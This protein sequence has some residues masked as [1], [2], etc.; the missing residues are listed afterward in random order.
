MS[1]ISSLC[2]ALEYIAREMDNGDEWILIRGEDKKNWAQ[3][4][5]SA[6]DI[7]KTQSEKLHA[8]AM[9]RND[10]Y[11]NGG[12]ISCDDKLPE[13]GKYVLVSFEFRGVCTA[14][15]AYAHNGTSERRWYLVGEDSRYSYF[16]TE[17]KAWRPLP[18]PY[19][20]EDTE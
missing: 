13:F 11:Y 15:I 10:Q 20:K 19:D 16:L 7:I 6:I 2:V 3:A 17:A 18:A 1:M 4:I 12:W 9:E 8:Y 14:H 5:R